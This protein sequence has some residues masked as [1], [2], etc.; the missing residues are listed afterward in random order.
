LMTELHHEFGFSCSDVFSDAIKDDEDLSHRVGDRVAEIE[1]PFLPQ[2]DEAAYL[3]VYGA[4][5]WMVPF[6]AQLARRVVPDLVWTPLFGRYHSTV[7]GRRTARGRGS[8][9]VVMVFDPL[10][11]FQSAAET[12]RDARLR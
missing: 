3:Q 9:K 5:H 8:R 12:L 2:R 4:C 6:F 11:S 1:A 7:V 10:R